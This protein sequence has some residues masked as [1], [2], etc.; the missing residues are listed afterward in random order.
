MLYLRNGWV[1]IAWTNQIADWTEKPELSLVATRQIPIE[2]ELH[3]DFL[4]IRASLA[5]E[6]DLGRHGI[7]GPQDL[8]IVTLRNKKAASFWDQCALRM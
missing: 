6:Q 7:Y 4:D 3:P 8:S 5:Q 1:E 2:R